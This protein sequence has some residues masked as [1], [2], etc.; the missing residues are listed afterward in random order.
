MSKY[1]N[2]FFVG[3][4][5]NALNKPYTDKLPRMELFI[6]TRNNDYIDF[7][8][9]EYRLHKHDHLEIFYF[10]SGKGFFETQKDKIPVKENTLLIVN[11]DV[12]H[13]Q[14]STCKP[15]LLFY[16]IGFSSLNLENLPD[17]C[18]SA[19]EYEVKEF[20]DKKNKIFNTF[21]LIQKET[22]QNNSTFLSLQSKAFVLLDEITKIFPATEKN[23]NNNISDLLLNE[24]RFYLSDN[25]ELKITLDELSKRFFIS[26][27]KL[28]HEF[29]KEFGIAPID[30]L[31]NVRLEKAET[32]LAK[33]D[34][35]IVD[36]AFECGFTS[37]NY[38][39][40]HFKKKYGIAPSQYRK[41]MQNE[42]ENI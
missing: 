30:Y 15:P 26:K 16:N 3:N 2:L 34:K 7:D 14:Y 40:D 1:Y 6:K 12:L 22:S 28:S 17:N 29:K 23:E 21:T 33:T 36:V 24:I 20:A 19:N 41:N 18:I 5:K 32:L 35:P 13:R 37:S 27:S 11:A 9:P 31:V 39:S 8:N 38:F 25:Y 10:I 4:M 42:R